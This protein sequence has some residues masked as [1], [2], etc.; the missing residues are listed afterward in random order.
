MSSSP[1]LTPNEQTRYRWSQK[2]RLFFLSEITMTPLL[3]QENLACN[4]QRV[5]LDLPFRFCCLTWDGR[6]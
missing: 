1:T 5:S 4:Y 2:I 6:N 3:I